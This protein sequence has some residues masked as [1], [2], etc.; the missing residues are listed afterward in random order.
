MAHELVAVTSGI[1][2]IHSQLAQIAARRMEQFTGL[3][4]E[5]LGEADLRRCGLTDPNHLKFRLFDLV[6]A[7]NVLYFDADAFCLQPWDPRPFCNRPE[8]TAVRGFTFDPRMEQL[9]RIYGFGDATFNGGFFLCNRT[10]H[11]RALRLG[12]SLQPED[13]TFHGLVN[14]DEIAFGTA[15]KILDIPIRFL[16]RRYNWIQFGRGNLSHHASSI[17]AHA[18]DTVLRSAYLNGQSFAIGDA[19]PDEELFARLGGRVWRYDRIGYDDRAMELRP[20]GTIGAGSGTVERYYFGVRRTGRTELVI[21]SVFEETCTLTEGSDGVWR[22]R[23]SDYEQMPVTLMRH[24][25]QVVIDLLTQRGVQEK[26]LAGVEVGV[27]RGETSALLLR[28]LPGLHLHLVDPWRTS[29]DEAAFWL[30]GSEGDPARNQALFDDIMRRA[31]SATEFAADRRT[32]VP[33]ASQTA[34]RHLEETFD[35]IFIDAGDHAE[36]EVARDIE[37]WHSRLRPGG[38]LCGHDYAHPEFPGVKRAVD[39]FAAARH[40]TVQTGHDYV[41]YFDTS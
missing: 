10:H 18:C 35:L 6:D 37:A 12:E 31:V 9:G 30:P 17:I 8:W 24:R 15:L 27:F 21:G 32:I 3:P 7:E 26:R 1:G 39:E 23:W 33:C 5:I 40:L 4:V 14:P 16:D 2:E 38:L 22:G 34:A 20:D 41:W 13:G 36:R 29:V 28:G 19:H 11:V 25:A